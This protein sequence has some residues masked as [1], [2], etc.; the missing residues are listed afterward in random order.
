MSI[1]SVVFAGLIVKFSPVIG[2]S[3][4]GKSTLIRLLAGLEDPTTG[5]V[6]LGEDEVSGPGPDRGMRNNFV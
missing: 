6:L 3:G 2:A 5:R 1:V 4:C